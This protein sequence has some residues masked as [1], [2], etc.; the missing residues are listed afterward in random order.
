MSLLYS[1]LIYIIGPTNTY[2]VVL[3][4]LWT[5]VLGITRFYKEDYLIVKWCC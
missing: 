3:I 2:F 4:I 5:N 1:N